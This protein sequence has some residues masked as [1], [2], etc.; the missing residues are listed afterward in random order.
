MVSAEVFITPVMLRT[1]SE[2]WPTASFPVPTTLRLCW[3]MSTSLFEFSA[4]FCMEAKSSSMEAVVW[5]TEAD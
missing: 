2:D 1:P 4:T 5:V 3:A